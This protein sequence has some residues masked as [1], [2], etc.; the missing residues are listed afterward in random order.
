MTIA[1]MRQFGVNV[2]TVA[3]NHYIIPNCGYRAP[4]SDDVVLVEADASS[5]TYAL[6][7]AAVTGNEVTVEGV[8]SESL[9]GDASFCR[10]LE[11]MGCEVKQTKMS[12]TVRGPGKQG[13]L[14][15]IDIDMMTMTDAF[16]TLAAVAA[17][18]NGVTKITGI[19][20]QRVKECDRIAAMVRELAKCGVRVVFECD[21]LYVKR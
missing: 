7:I 16:M 10:A 6:A 15:A 11:K 8:G 17:V 2:E 3:D 21:S 19:A 4:T 13:G 1:A 12:T 18:S 20:N 14:Q 9:Q 5:A